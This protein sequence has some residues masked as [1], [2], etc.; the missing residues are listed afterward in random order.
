[1]SSSSRTVQ[2]AAFEANL[3]T[4]EL[5]KQGIRIHVTGQAF[6]MLVMLLDRPRELI[7]RNELRARLWG[8]ET[9]VDFEAG[10]NK[11]VNRLREALN[12][13]ASNPRYIETVAR[14]GYRFLVPVTVSHGARG[15]SE[16]PPRIRLAVLPFENLSADSEQEFFS[17]GL[18]EEIISELGRLDPKRL[19]V[20]ART[21]AMLYK[22][23]GKGIDEIGRDL[24]VDY[25]LEGS[26]RKAERRVRITV[27]LIRVPDQ[28]HLWAES[29]DRDLA[30]IFRVQREVAGRVADSLTCE[31]LPYESA[32]PSH[33]SPDAYEAYLRGR[34]SWN[35]GSDKQARTAI[36]WFE[37]C[38]KHDPKYALA[39]SGIADC[40]GRLGWF[41]A[42]PHR[43]AGARAEAAAARA[44][45][46]S[47]GLAEAHASMALAWF[48]HQWNWREAERE[49]REARRLRP[50]YAA[51]RLWYS[52]FLN[53][54]QRFNEAAD[55][56]RVAEE[57][58]PLSL[59]IAMNAADPYYFLRQYPSAIERLKHVLER[60]PT[61]FPAHYN[62]GRAYLQCRMFDEAVSSFATAAEISG[63]RQASAALAHAYGRCGE[64]RKAHAILEEMETSGAEFHV[65]SPQLAW[66]YLGLGD[67]R[68]AIEKLEKGL[69]ERSFWM[70]Y[71]QADPVYDELRSD[72]AFDRLLD[73]MN[74]PTRPA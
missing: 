60:D 4:G 68:G 28:T 61:F 74:F 36:Q 19:G 38:L 63:V 20:I 26:V 51:A 47:P 2:F 21:S 29:Y 7:T 48:W 56:Q 52:A 57:L 34:F 39:Y 23:C 65:A 44:L 18:T 11:I 46:L 67:L 9:F 31:L 35:Q 15:S 14:R 1:M 70:V 55:E 58:D 13:S 45:A 8:E 12:D 42:L 5:R 50:N 25:I 73:R 30:D 22:R 24:E 41:G 69:E 33:V 37:R 54:R 72:P 6:Q 10:L 40:Y 17:D 43:E 16:S 59:T 62:L 71:I 53:V 32:D 27:Q 66:I 3:E 49:F 64:I